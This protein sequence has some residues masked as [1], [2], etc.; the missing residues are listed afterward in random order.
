MAVHALRL[1]GRHLPERQ[2]FGEPAS[3]QVLGRAGQQ[4]EQRPAGRIGPPRAAIEP[5][6]HRRR[7]RRRVRAGRC[8]AAATGRARPS[9]RSARRRGRCRIRRAISR[10]SRPSP[11]AENSCTDS[12]SLCLRRR[13]RREQ[14]RARAARALPPAPSS[15]HGVDRPHQADQRIG[16]ARSSAATVTSDA[17]RAGEQRSDDIGL[18]WVADG[19]VQQNERLPR[20]T[21]SLTATARAAVASTC[22][23]RRKASLRVS[24]CTRLLEVGQ[25][26]PRR[27][28]CS[29]TSNPTPACETSPRVRATARGKS[30]R[31]RDWLEVPQIVGLLEGRASGHA[32]TLEWRRDRR[33]LT[34]QR[35]GRELGDQLVE[36]VSA[37]AEGRASRRAR[38]RASSSAAPREAATIVSSGSTEKCWKE[39]RGRPGVGPRRRRSISLLS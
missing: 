24:A 21:R 30:R 1:A 10:H 19:H 4:R 9:R 25:I 29:Q 39:T 32:S 13:V 11:G 26:G 15:A 22:G 2:V 28:E 7:A 8:T 14:V 31:R 12:S 16:V 5:R 34:R 17:C 37:D 3:G 23:P 36:P 38:P 18:E 20:A 33:S 6:G 35:H 27:A